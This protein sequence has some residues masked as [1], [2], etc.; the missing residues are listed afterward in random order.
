MQLNKTA[1]GLASGIL[2]GAAILLTTLWVMALG[3]GEHLM[4]LSKFY[5]GY[6][7]SVVGAVVGL[8]YGFIEGF[9]CG[10][11]FAWLYNRL[12]PARGSS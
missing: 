12:A 8:I 5:I 1:L 10:W 9:V 4:L 11:I 7:V 6:S 3:G 2:W